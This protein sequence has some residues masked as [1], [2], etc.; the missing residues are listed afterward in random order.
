MEVPKDRGSPLAGPNPLSV[1]GAAAR[2]GAYLLRLRIHKD[3]NISFGRFQQSEAIAIPAGEYIYIGSAMNPKSGLA[4]RL[5]RHATRSESRSSHPIQA[6]MLSVFKTLGLGNQDL[7]PPIGKKLHWN[8]DHL[9]DQE[10]VELANALLIRTTCDLEQEL[11]RLLENDPCT[12]IIARGLGASDIPGNTHLLRVM[13]DES[14]WGA[15]NLR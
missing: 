3:L 9:L 11:G 7:S 5:L 14:W 6:T 15:W 1:L 12:E 4:R 13:A 10:E 8:I 2:T